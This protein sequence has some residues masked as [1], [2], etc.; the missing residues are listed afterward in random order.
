M[1]SMQTIQHY[2]QLLPELTLWPGKRCGCFP[3]HRNTNAFKMKK[4]TSFSTPAL[5]L[6]VNN[7]ERWAVIKATKGNS[8]GEDELPE[9]EHDPDAASIL[10][11][12][13]DDPEKLRKRI[14]ERIKKKK[15]DILQTKTGSAEPMIVTFKDF[16]FSDSCY[17]WF[18]FSHS[19]SNDELDL[20]S[21]TI[22]SWYLLGHTGGYNSLNMQLTKLP[23]NEMPSFDSVKAS[24][25]LTSA[26]CNIG[27]LEIQDNLAR[28]WV[29]IGTSD[30]LMLDVLINALQSLSSDYIG[31][32][33]LV[34]GG[35]FWGKWKEGSNSVED[36]YKVCKI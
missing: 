24:E 20:I 8:R 17:I 23:I 13:F 1:Q 27:D 19:P 3:S 14:E 32:K 21:G 31:I 11:G 33:N 26:F 36:G 12:Q 2:A 5:H 34:L 9:F 28:I 7:F 6:T 4:T 25:E 18:E 10:M 16:D 29:D 15:K 22:R 35:K 30:L